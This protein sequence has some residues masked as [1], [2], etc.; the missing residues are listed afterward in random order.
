MNNYELMT[1]KLQEVIG[2]AYLDELIQQ[3][4]PLNGYWGTEPS[5]TIHIGYLLCF[6]KIRDCVNAGANITILLADIHAF[7]NAKCPFEKISFRTEYYE[8]IITAVLKKMNVDM[9]KI[10]FVK[11]SSYQLTPEFTM[12]RL[13]MGDIIN[14]SRAKKAA[15]EVVKLSN[16]PTLNSLEYPIMQALDQHYLNTNFE[17][18][19][20]DQRKV[21]GLAIEIMSKIGYC[22]RYCYLMNSII[23]GISRKARACS[24]TNGANG[25]NDIE[26]DIENKMS[27]SD[28]S[29]KIYLLYEPDKILKI[30]NKAYCLDGDVDDNSLLRIIK[31]IVFALSTEFSIVKYDKQT[32]NLINIKTYMDYDALYID[33]AKGSKNGGIHPADLKY[34]LSEYFIQFLRPIRDEFDTIEGKEL[35]SNAFS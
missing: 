19:G 7:L 27:A 11:G 25:A 15:S 31:D 28:D 9:S 23:P 5:G 16:N 10:K 35:L 26:M 4:I 22:S 21:F 32:N 2:G 8:K 20:I 13:K 17:L 1:H 29:S 3:Q 33:V 6:A 30:I 24:D 12:D 18:S 14:V 34:S